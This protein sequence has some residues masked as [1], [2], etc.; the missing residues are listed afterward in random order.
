MILGRPTNLWLGV[1]SAALATLQIILVQL[2]YD[3]TAVA[4]ILGAVGLLLGAIIALIANQPPTVAPGSTVNVQTPAGQD[5][6]TVT[7]T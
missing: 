3:A 7:V 4:T 5:N 6:R 2:G 1:V